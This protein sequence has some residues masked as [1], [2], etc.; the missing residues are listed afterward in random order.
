MEELLL[1]VGEQVGYITFALRFTKAVVVILR[2][3]P[4]I[5]CLIES[6]LHADHQPTVMKRGYIET[7]DLTT[8]L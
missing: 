2:D 6:S 4:C 7:L 8:E 5:Y 1:A 3:E